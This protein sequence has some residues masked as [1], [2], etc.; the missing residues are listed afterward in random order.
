MASIDS[1]V[2]ATKHRNRSLR[3][4]GSCLDFERAFM[5]I[6]TGLVSVCRARVQCAANLQQPRIFGVRF[7][8]Q[9]PLF[10]GKYNGAS[11]VDAARLTMVFS[12]ARARDFR[13]GA[14]QYL[15]SKLTRAKRS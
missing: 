6:G 9:S 8:Q 14:P 13:G 12:S 5:Q 1:G 11:Q 7:K 10:L 4:L 2:S 15:R 3:R